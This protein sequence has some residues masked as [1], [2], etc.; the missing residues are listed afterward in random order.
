[1]APEGTLDLILKIRALC[2]KTITSQDSLTPVIPKEGELGLVFMRLFLLKNQHHIFEKHIFAC[3]DNS[4]NPK[5]VKKV[6]EIIGDLIQLNKLDLVP[7][8][9]ETLIK[10]LDDKKYIFPPKRI[11]KYFN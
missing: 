8:I 4:L 2:S 9:F 11:K 3:L 10:N 5:G 7:R 6:L 1:M